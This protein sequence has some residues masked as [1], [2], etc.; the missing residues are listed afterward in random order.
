LNDTITLDGR[1]F[2]GVSQALTSSQDDYILAHL[3]VA[4]ALEVL[5]DLDGVEREPKQR[6]DELLT[7]ILLSGRKQY[8]LAGCLTEVGKTWNRSDAERNAAKFAAL[9]GAEEKAAMTS[10]IVTFVIGFFQ[11]GEQSSESSP[12]SSSQQGKGRRTKS[13]AP[14]IS[15]SSL[16]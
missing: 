15:A 16:Q 10:A 2:H 8:I 9:T 11:L 1:T 12:K 14:A 7:R 13:A 4:G 5:G 3:R 6:A